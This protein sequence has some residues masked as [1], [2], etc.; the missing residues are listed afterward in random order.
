MA[1]FEQAL[2]NGNNGPGNVAGGVNIDDQGNNGLAQAT[3]IEECGNVSRGKKRG[4]L[5]GYTLFVTE[6]TT[7]KRFKEVGTFMLLFY[8]IL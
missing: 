4:H 8:V 1:E 7:G 5:N 2:N 3:G 6:E